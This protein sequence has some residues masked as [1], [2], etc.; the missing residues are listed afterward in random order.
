MP[1]RRP[2]CEA[3]LIFINPS[4]RKSKAFCQATNSH[5]DHHGMQATRLG[6]AQQ[7]TNSH[8]D[9]NGEDNNGKDKPV[10]YKI[11]SLRKVVF[12]LTSVFMLTKPHAYKAPYRLDRPT[13]AGVLVFPSEVASGSRPTN[14]LFT[15][16]HPCA[17]SPKRFY[18]YKRI[19]YVVY[20]THPCAK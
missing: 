12:M 20:K 11:S 14:T 4:L 10:V 1:S 7:A 17:K 6:G 3:M 13:L 16:P 9:R 15:K 2:A 8:K 18:A 19:E 5:K